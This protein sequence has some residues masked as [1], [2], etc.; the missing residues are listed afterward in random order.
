MVLESEDGFSGMNG[1]FYII[2]GRPTK[3]Y[4]TGIKES[5][6]GYHNMT[7]WGVDKAGN[8]CE[9]GTLWFFVDNEAP[10]TS[11]NYD[12]PL[13]NAGGK[14]FVTPQTAIS[15]SSSDSGSGVNRTEYKLDNQ[16]Y[17]A[18]SEPLKLTTAGQ[19][20]ILYRSSDKVGN[21]EAETTLK[22]TVDTTPPTTKGT[23]S[24]ALSREDISVTLSATDADSGVCATYYRVVKE[25]ATPPDYQSGTE[26][27]ITAGSDGKDDGNYTV[28]YYSVDMLGNKETAKE[29]KVKI[30]T[31][32]L[33]ELATPGKQSGGHYTR[34]GRTEPGSKVTVNSEPVTL[35]ADGSFSYEVVLKPGGNKVTVQ[36]TDSAGN[37]ASKTEDVTYNEPAAD[38]GLLIPIVAIVAAAAC[39]GAGVF[40]LMRKKKK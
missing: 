6:P 39:A 1:T 36:A 8:R 14:V 3:P 17:K 9:N 20:T 30:D 35:S 24:A 31:V 37:T 28:Q 2:D 13:A 18:Y 5:A 33:L 4:G 38:T 7:Y 21:S 16:A 12:G 19:H 40:L 15:L 32:V 27:V 29:L 11:V 10:V 23:A 22:V 26:V 25:K 34:K